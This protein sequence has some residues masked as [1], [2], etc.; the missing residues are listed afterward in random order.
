MLKTIH[1]LANLLHVTHNTVGQPVEREMQTMESEAFMQNQTL[2]GNTQVAHSSE[3]SLFLARRTELL[4]RNRSNPDT[5][6][7]C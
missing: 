2:V 3:R 1:R 5:V 4:C 7:H 6:E